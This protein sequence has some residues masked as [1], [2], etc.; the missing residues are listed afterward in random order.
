MLHVSKAAK[1][2]METQNNIAHFGIFGTE[3]GFYLERN[4][5]FFE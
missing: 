3:F 4:L 1:H 5:C 2:V